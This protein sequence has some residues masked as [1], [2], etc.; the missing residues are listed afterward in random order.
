M[1]S[2]KELKDSPSNILST[3]ISH[4]YLGTDEIDER[5]AEINKV[6]KE[7]IVNFAKKV[8]VDTVYVLE[9]SDDDE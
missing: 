2:V 7:M 3:Y 1:N 6:T 4:E 5:C 8:H 9:G